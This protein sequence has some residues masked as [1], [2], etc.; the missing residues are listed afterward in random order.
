MSAGNGLD[1]VDAGDHFNT[2]HYDLARWNHTYLEWEPSGYDYT[3]LQAKESLARKRY[4]H[5]NATWRVIR[6]EADIRHTDM[7]CLADRE[8]ANGN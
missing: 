2:S 4:L 5:P 6:V 3:W 1:P 7:T 8:L